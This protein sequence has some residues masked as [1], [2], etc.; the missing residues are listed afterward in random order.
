MFLAESIIETIQ[1]FITNITKNLDFGILALIALGLFAVLLIITFLRIRFGAIEV[2]TSRAINK[3][4]NY[5]LVTP[6]V[7]EENLVEFN[8]LMKKIPDSMRLQWQDYMLNRSEKPS[9]YINQKNVV[10]NPF[11]TSKFKSSVTNFNLFVAILAGLSFIINLASLT[12]QTEAGYVLF[13]SSLIPLALLVLAVIFNLVFN[14]WRSSVTSNCYMNIEQL[15]KLIDRATTTMPPYVDYE[16]LFTKK[17]ISRGIP[18]LQEYLQQRAQFEQEEIEKAKQS[19]VEH[20]EY[21]FSSLGVNGSLVMDRAMKESEFYLGNRRRYLQEIEQIE[22][23]KDM[24]TRNYDDKNKTSQRKLRDIKETLDRLKEK[25]DSTTNKIVANDIRRQQ[26]E[27]IKKQQTVEKE[28]EEDNA[29]YQ[30]ELQKLEDEV[31]NRKAEIDKSRKYVEN[32]LNG[33][34]KEYADKIYSEIKQGLDEQYYNSLNEYEYQRQDIEQRIE[35]K[36]KYVAERDALYQ[37]KLNLIDQYAQALQDRDT[38]IR[39]LTDQLNEA[40]NTVHKRDVNIK[41]ELDDKISEMQV[42]DQDLYNKMMIIKDQDSKLEEYRNRVEQLEGQVAILENQKPEVK[43]VYRYFDSNGDEFFLDET[44][45][46]YYIDEKG[47]KRYYADDN[48]GDDEGALKED[49]S[50]TQPQEKPVEAEEPKK[51]EQKPVDEPKQ[52]EPKPEQKQDKKSPKEDLD[53]LQK[54]IEEE[55]VKLE[56]QGKELQ[57]R[58]EEANEIS[59]EEDNPIKFED[60]FGDVDINQ[61]NEQINTAISDMEKKPQ[62]PAKKRTPRNKM[63]SKARNAKK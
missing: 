23:E 17:E 36:D 39:A 57:E 9:K 61:F 56:S 24:L 58:L 12:G 44:G 5:L 30:R 46:P 59:K 29:K 8:N 47:N 35:E 54:Q 19:E 31:A 2:K 63:T 16:I 10:E 6:F 1:N 3:I 15:G 11:K 14:G 45:K 32:T 43:E 20:D 60:I 4:A 34:F 62:Q 48:N 22:S 40:K 33:E 53:A 41:K 38:E 13:Q 27:E 37:E 25:L 42:K 21:D 51:E 26:G 18:A 49:N 7:T 55:N 28:M 52:E 50:S